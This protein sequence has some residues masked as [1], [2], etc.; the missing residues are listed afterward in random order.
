MERY[1]CVC[2]TPFI[3]YEL[4]DHLAAIPPR[5][6]FQQRVY[7]K[8]IVEE[9]PHAAHVPWAYTEGRITASPAYEL[10]REAFNFARSRLQAML[11]QA[12]NKPP[13][14]EFRD[15][16]R[17]MRED[18]RLAAVIVDF[19]RSDWFPADVLDAQGVRRFVEE[20]RA[21]GGPSQG[22][23]YS[24]LCG[25]AKAIE[26][27]LASDRIRVPPLADPAEFGVHP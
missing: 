12:K 24:H 13:R 26:M 4:A 15:N 27:F 3:D 11:P 5:W 21:G 8:M 14:W 16:A 20:F 25:L 2:R 19:T 10:A 1:F 23:M 7:K 17:M 6:R 22:I 9:F 18:P